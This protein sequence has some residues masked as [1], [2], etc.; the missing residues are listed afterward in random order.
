MELKECKH[1]YFSPNQ[2][3]SLSV[4]FLLHILCL[5]A[6]EG[7]SPYTQFFIFPFPNVEKTTFWTNMI[8]HC[9]FLSLLFLFRTVPLGTDLFQ[10]SCG[11]ITPL[12]ASK[13]HWIKPWFQCSWNHWFC[14]SQDFTFRSCL[15][16]EI[17]RVLGDWN[18]CMN[19]R[20]L[21]P[22]FWNV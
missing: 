6:A 1:S 18:C 14:V 15:Y 5:Y 22:A 19:C 3:F 7:L 10:S 21:Q 8:Y 4:S 20:K 2:Y 12:W 16:F 13:G 11:Y 9:I 17:P